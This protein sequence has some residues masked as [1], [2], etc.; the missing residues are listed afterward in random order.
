MHLNLGVTSTTLD[1]QAVSSKEEKPHEQ[2]GLVLQ[3]KNSLGHIGCISKDYS[4][5]TTN[6][7]Q[8]LWVIHLPKRSHTKAYWIRFLDVIMMFRSHLLQNNIP[9]FTEKVRHIFSCGIATFYEICTVKR[10][11]KCESKKMKNTLW[12]DNCLGKM[13]KDQC[14]QFRTPGRCSP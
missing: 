5:I 14:P 7:N 3:S 8:Q 2:R 10:A 1:I 13:G 11:E 6:I 4:Y 12:S 9:S